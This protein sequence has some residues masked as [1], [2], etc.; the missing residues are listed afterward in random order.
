MMSEMR[1]DRNMSEEERRNNMASIFSN[2]SNISVTD[3]ENYGN[4][5]YVK[6]YYYTLSVGADSND[7]EK[8]TASFGNAGFSG[9]SGGRTGNENFQNMSSG[10]FTLMGYSSISSMDDF[11]SGKYSIISGNLS[12]EFESATCVINSELATLNDIA[13]G[14][15]IKFIDPSD[16]SNIIA[17]T[18]TGIF[19]ETSDA[20]SAMGMFSSSANTII[21]NVNVINT[22]TSKND[23]LKSSLTP[24][25]ILTNKEV[26]ESFENELS[27]KGLNEYL[28]VSTNLDQVEGATKTIS[29]VNTFATT[30]LIITFIIGGI[31]LFVIN[32]I[33]IRE[34]KYEIGVLRTIG[35]KKRYLTMQF[36]CELLMVSFVALVIGAGIGAVSSVPVSNYLLESEISSSS[37]QMENINN[38]FGGKMEFGNKG[39]NKINGVATVQ[40]F[41]SIDAA[42]DLKVLLQLFGIG[43]ILTL[44]SSMAS[45][46]S[47]QKFS[48]L[49]ILKERS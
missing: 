5:D 13:V 11:I 32:M 22:F 1:M 41:D 33:N 27:Q 16:E 7:I 45:M 34:R 42:V 31:V 26:I 19:E 18:V 37:S 44:I 15:E 25:F 6:E 8:A 40:T 24:T 30:F 20:D 3:V 38:N 28:T 17:L 14:D 43:T 29:N 2:A 10:D 46:I 35:M 39:M 47:I 12:D 48:P 9:M 36:I 23:E 4:S 49:T 21:T